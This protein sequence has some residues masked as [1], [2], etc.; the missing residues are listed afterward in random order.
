MFGNPPGRLIDDITDRFG[1][2]DENEG[3]EVENFIWT[4]DAS[5]TPL[6]TSWAAK[7]RIR[8]EIFSW[9]RASHLSLVFSMCRKT[10]DNW[11]HSI[12]NRVMIKP[13]PYD[14]DYWVN[15]KQF[16]DQNQVPN[17]TRHWDPFELNRSHSLI[18]KRKEKNKKSKWTWVEQWRTRPR[19]EHHVVDDRL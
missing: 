18:T 5:E 1:W 11:Y 14:H 12:S 10:I 8:F 2:L 16:D 7:T 3:K 15:G 13:I 4:F 6:G 17:K 9:D 19:Y